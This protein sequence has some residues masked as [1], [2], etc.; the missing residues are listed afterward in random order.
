MG[1]TRVLVHASHVYVSAF[2][3]RLDIHDQLLHGLDMDLSEPM[4]KDACLWVFSNLQ[5]LVR[6]Q[7]SRGGISEGRMR[8]VA[9]CIPSIAALA[10][11]GKQQV[12]DDL[13]VHFKEADGHPENCLVRVL[14]DVV[15]DI[16]NCPRNYSKLVLRGSHLFVLTLSQQARVLSH[17]V[18]V[19]L[20]PEDCVRLS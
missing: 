15:K 4:D 19:A 18:Q 14:F 2:E 7:R 17:V 16:L 20:A 9:T 8:T 1:S 13:H 10:L 5:L 11:R 12:S 6:I 3:P